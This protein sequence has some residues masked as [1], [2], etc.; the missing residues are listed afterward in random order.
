VCNI[1]ITEAIK[2]LIECNLLFYNAVSEDLTVWN[3][4]LNWL[5]TKILTKS[6]CGVI[7]SIIYWK[8]AS[9]ILRKQTALD[10][11]STESILEKWES[12]IGYINNGIH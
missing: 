11:V 9:T 7:Q 6:M 5:W 10:F 2:I 3:R 4:L 8:S 1:I 12:T